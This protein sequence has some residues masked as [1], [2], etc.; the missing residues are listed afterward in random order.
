MPISSANFAEPPCENEDAEKIF[1]QNGCWFKKVT[2]ICNLN[3]KRKNSDK[4][5]KKPSFVAA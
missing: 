5:A 3:Y 2:Y 1:W 4:T